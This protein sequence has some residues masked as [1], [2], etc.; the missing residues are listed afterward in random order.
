M[1]IYSILPNSSYDEKGSRNKSRR[2]NQS[3]C[4]IFKTFFSEIVAF[5]R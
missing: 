1:R 2:E 5:M 3:T 4:F